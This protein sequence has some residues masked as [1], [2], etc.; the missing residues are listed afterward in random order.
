L[1]KSISTPSGSS[2]AFSIG[3][4]VRILALALGI[5]FPPVGGGLTRTFHL[6]KAIASH[7]DVTLIGFTYEG[8]EPHE[9]PPY[10]LHVEAVPW[11]WSR[12]YREM[13]GA[14]AAA[15]ARAYERLAYQCDQ[16]WFASVVDRGP[17]QKTLSKVLAT[18]P[19]VVLLEGMPLAQFLPW[20]PADVPRVLD[21]FDV[22][23]VMERHA[24]G[25]E[26]PRTLAFERHAVRACSSCL[27][28]SAADAEAARSLLG[29]SSVHLVPNGVDTSYFMPS[30]MPIETGSLLF[31]GRMNYPPN[32][33][34]ARFFAREILPLVREAAPH[35]RFH[36]VGADPTADVRALASEAVVVHGRVDDVRPF[37][38]NSEVVVVPVRSGG[39]TRL[40]VLEA[41][42]SG[43]P[44]VS[45]HLGV[46]GLDF[47]ADDVVIADDALAFAH[48]VLSLLGNPDA[49]RAIGRRA[50]LV[51]GRYEWS[52]IGEAFR[53]ILEQSTF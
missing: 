34:A 18:P 44:I 52:K 40:K 22:H 32:V 12:D 2:R 8:S 20:L 16:P 42:A 6:L 50:Q 51:A 17:M 3:R 21:L 47:G 7:H 14:D 38:A 43:K 31:T 5:P 26:A 35:A 46:E 48:A 39:G 9:K 1:P 45:T 36:I 13:I 28:V 24:G 19:D 15:A 29:A 4:S 23:S 33:D 25:P 10:P 30:A 11:Q 37:L 41:A 53:G 27:A 49:R